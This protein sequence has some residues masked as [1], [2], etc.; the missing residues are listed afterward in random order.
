LEIDLAEYETMLILQEMKINSPDFDRILA[1]IKRGGDVNAQDHIGFTLLRYTVIHDQPAI[2]FE[3]LKLGAKVEICGFDEKNFLSFIKNKPHFLEMYGRFLYPQLCHDMTNHAQSPFDFL[4][5]KKNEDHEIKIK[6]LLLYGKWEAKSLLLFL[7]SADIFHY[8]IDN[9][10]L[11]KLANQIKPQLHLKSLKSQ[12]LAVCNAI[13]L[14][15]NTELSVAM[16]HYMTDTHHS[17]NLNQFFNQQVKIKRTPF[18]FDQ[19]QKVLAA[20]ESFDAVLESMEE[21][22]NSEMKGVGLSE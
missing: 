16:F 20:E 2:A 17:T 4:F 12:A 1:N 19:S 3:L 8:Q 9:E 21:R 11:N 18:L 7:Y 22:L 13:L 5:E 10:I 14:D 15:D 6:A